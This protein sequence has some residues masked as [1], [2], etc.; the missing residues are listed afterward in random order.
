MKILVLNCGSSSVKFQLLD[1]TD[2]KVV[3]KGM[4]EKVGTSA[5]IIT[6]K[7]YKD[8][9]IRETRE[10]LNHTQALSAVIGC[11]GHPEY[12][13]LKSRS[14]IE[15]VGHRVVHGGERFAHSVK[16]TT[17]VL[18]DITKCIELAP[19]HNP[20][21]LSGISASIALLPDALQVGVFDTAFHQKM[22]RH[23]FIYGL[24]YN[25]YKRWGI[26]RYGFHGTSHYYVSRV[27]AEWIG[28]PIEE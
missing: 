26:R 25:L 17:E 3:A 2:E 21:N 23:A 5:A 18:D 28:R 6:M 13:V 1:M 4:V 22:P 24:P 11:L 20:A 27:A 12:G 16:I 7:T 14:E 15:A 9:S 8:D 10:I 19:L